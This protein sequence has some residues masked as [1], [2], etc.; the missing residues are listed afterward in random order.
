MIRSVLV[1][2]MVLGIS[3][4]SMAAQEEKIVTSGPEIIIHKMDG[5]PLELKHWEHQKRMK[6]GGC[7]NCHRGEIGKIEGW[8]KEFAHMVC[9]PCHDLNDKGPV[10]CKEC[11][12]K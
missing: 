9:I 8:N 7:T 6:K 3:G 12:K 10:N 11:H 1:F 5:K 4:I 2:V